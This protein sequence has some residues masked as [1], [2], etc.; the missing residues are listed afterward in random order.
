MAEKTANEEEVSREQAADLIEE[1]ARELRS[2]GA[3]EV[4]VGNKVLTLTP[5]PELEYGIEVR[6]RS[7]MLGGERQEITVTIDWEVSDEPT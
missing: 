5:A 3:A 4:T 2:E 1:L 6:E 7:P